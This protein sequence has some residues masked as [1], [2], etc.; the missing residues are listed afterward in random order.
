M[1]T[2]RPHP[3]GP[4]RLLRGTGVRVSILTAVLVLFAA[5]LAPGASATSSGFYM[6]N[7]STMSIRSGDGC[8]LR[9]APP[10]GNHQAVRNFTCG[11][12]RKPGVLPAQPA[13]ARIQKM[14]NGDKFTI[15]SAD[16]CKIKTAPPSSGH[17]YIRNFVCTGGSSVTT[18]PPA[19]GQPPAAVTGGATWRE[20]F[21]DEFT[22]TKV[23]ASKW[24]VGDNS[25]YGDSNNEDECYK[26]SNVTEAN[27]TL[28]LTGKRQTVTNC[29]SNPNGGDSYYFTSGLVTTRAQFGGL[30]MRFK[31]GY[32]EV[33]MRVPRG[34]IYWPAF[35]LADPDDGS[36]P[37]WPAYGEIDVSEIYG[38]HPDVSESNFHKTGGD[39]GAGV[40]NVNR[41]GS[42]SSGININ[43]PNAFVAGGTQAWHTYGI[44][45]LSGRLDWYID[46][47]K[48]RTYNAVN[49]ADTNGLSYY[50]SIILNLAMGGDGPQDEGYSGRESG[51]TYSNGNLVADLPGTM[52]IDYAR[53][54]Q[55]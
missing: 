41:P 47:V 37:G 23:D 21:A 36:A 52:E 32:A 25:N 13:A 16:R 2:R 50:H 40:H 24:N 46:G 14:Y 15:A 5:A 18:P 49:A 4:T 22:G 1:S 54:W 10:A 53:V 6:I 42:D 12:T 33:R 26:T 43:P 20:I 31:Q 30:K 45:W 28:R 51:G 55:K 27:G 34:N 7:G 44:N 39:I 35:W 38:S 3:T 19:S 17:L 9:T 29:G 11:F 8:K 48:V